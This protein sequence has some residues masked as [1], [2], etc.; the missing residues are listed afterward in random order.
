M[1][2]LLHLQEQTNEHMKTPKTF[3][4][5]EASGPEP[6][7]AAG[8]GQACEQL[9]GRREVSQQQLS[10]TVAETKAVMGAQGPGQPGAWF[11]GP[12]DWPLTCS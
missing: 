11:E 9:E 3:T 10:P 5:S 2:V 6:R 1:T 7:E 4:T 12:Q 8:A